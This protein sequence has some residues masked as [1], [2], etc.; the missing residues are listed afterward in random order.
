[1]TGKI[2]RMFRSRLTPL[3]CRVKTRI[4]AVGC[5]KRTLMKVLTLSLDTEL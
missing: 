4:A 2:L 1:M 5:N 3:L